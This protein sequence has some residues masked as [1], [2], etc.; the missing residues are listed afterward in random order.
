MRDIVLMV[1]LLE[2]MAAKPD[3][4]I[5][6]VKHLGMSERER[7]RHHNAELL[8]DAGLATW[9]SDSAV[10]I[11]NDGYDFLNAVNQDPPK[12]TAR[13]KELLGQGK[14]LLAVAKDIISIVNA[15]Q[16]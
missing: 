16:V 4:Y 11:T 2:D 6:L 15:I 7:K 12:Y 8:S 14:T 10:R 9:K 1:D 3:G 5:L 13:A